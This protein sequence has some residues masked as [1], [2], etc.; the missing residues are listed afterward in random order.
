[1]SRRVLLIG[2]STAIGQAI[3]SR[4]EAASDRVVGV[5]LEPSS[6]VTA[7]CA[8][9]AGAAE[10]VSTV[11][12]RHGGLDV[13]VAAAGMMPVAPAHETTEE[14][15]RAAFAGCVDTLFFPMRAAL[16]I[17]GAH[18]SIVAV[19]SV[20][21][22]LAAPWVPAYAAAKGAVESLVRQT[23]L[24]YARRGIR[25]NAVAPGLVGGSELSHASGGY[26]IG[27]TLS[28]EEVANAVFFLASPEASGITGVVL[29][30][31]GGLSIASPAA[32]TRPDL[33]D[34]LA[35]LGRASE[36]WPPGSGTHAAGSD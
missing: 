4:F 10:A 24:D 13:L 32:F 27:R 6:D 35:R 7:D 11:T 16:P 19:S 12:D 20:N 33:M 26:P 23:A 28:P 14:Q 2:A 21:A 22:F 36:S 29:P 30:V 17:L 1:M 9:P 34:R 25:V 31:D 3:R 15:W 5:S 18:S 8:T